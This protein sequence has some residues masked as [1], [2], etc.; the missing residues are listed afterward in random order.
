MTA[1]GI[2][3][4]LILLA[5][6]PATLYWILFV[7]NTPGWW[8]RPVGR[9]LGIKATALMLLCDISAAYQILGNDYPYRD[10][11][12]ITVFLLVVLGLWLQLGALVHERWKGR[13]NGRPS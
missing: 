4:V 6:V 5:A 1:D 3:R 8:R 7:F 9:A 2:A 13:R 12:R 10:V 11:A